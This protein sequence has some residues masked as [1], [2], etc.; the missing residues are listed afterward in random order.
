VLDGQGRPHAAGD[1]GICD[2]AGRRGA[3]HVILPIAQAVGELTATTK[4]T[5]AILHVTCG[6]SRPAQIARTGPNSRTPNT[7][8][9]RQPARGNTP[10]SAAATP[11]G[12]QHHPPAGPGL[13]IRCL[14]CRYRYVGPP[15][16]TG[17]PAPAGVRRADL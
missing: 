15:G 5:N 6:A 11:P 2:E 3:A 14:M 4:D 13:K 1:G 8:P 12:N 16:P 17:Q 9:G 10:T 7:A